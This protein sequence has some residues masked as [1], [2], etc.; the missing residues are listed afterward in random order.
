M[1][2]PPDGWDIW[3]IWSVRTYEAILWVGGARRGDRMVLALLERSEKG[4]IMKTFL[5][6]CL[7]A[8]TGCSRYQ[9]VQEAPHKPAPVALRAGQGKIISCGYSK[10]NRVT[11]LDVELPDGP[12]RV[13]RTGWSAV[14]FCDR[15]I[16]W[17]LGTD[18]NPD[19]PW[20]MIHRKDGKLLIGGMK[21]AIK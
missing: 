14:D 17:Q 12:H 19:K 3:E 5:F 9:G 15:V 20:A 2:I 4:D 21:W 11:T 7:L 8:L 16:Q 13:W 18:Y 1:G 10:A 6:V